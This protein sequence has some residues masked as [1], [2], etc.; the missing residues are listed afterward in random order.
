LPESWELAHLSPTGSEVK[1]RGAGSVR[2]V[3]RGE[4]GEGRRIAPEAAVN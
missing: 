1:K 3:Q 4:S 2:A